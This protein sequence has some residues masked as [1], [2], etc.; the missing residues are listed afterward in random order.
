VLSG[1]SAGFRHW[2]GADATY[3]NVKVSRLVESKQ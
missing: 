3:T 2:G 1:G